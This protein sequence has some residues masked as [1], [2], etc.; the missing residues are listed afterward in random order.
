MRIRDFVLFAISLVLVRSTDSALQDE[1]TSPTDGDDPWVMVVVEEVSVPNDAAATKGDPSPPTVPTPSIPIHQ[2]TDSIPT[3]GSGE[4][5]P[6]QNVD[7]PTPRPLSPTPSITVNLRPRQVNGEGT[8]GSVTNPRSTKYH[9]FEI[10]SRRRPSTTLMSKIY[11]CL[12][13]CKSCKRRPSSRGQTDDT[14]LL[15]SQDDDSSPTRHRCQSPTGKRQVN[16][17]FGALDEGMETSVDS[18]SSQS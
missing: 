5:S 3:D 16:L 11:N 15:H 2:S 7:L 1:S 18:D 9:A 14:L 10:D 17:T 6:S 12:C 4:D 13:Y 8:P